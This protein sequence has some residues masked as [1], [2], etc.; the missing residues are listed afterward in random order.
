MRKIDPQ[1]IGY[2]VLKSNIISRNL[3]IYL[4]IFLFSLISDGFISDNRYTPITLSSIG[5]L[6]GIYLLIRHWSLFFNEMRA[7]RYLYVALAFL[8]P[9]GV[10][11]IDT[12]YPDKRT[13]VFLTMFLY[14]FMGAVPIYIL[15]TGGNF[16]RLE[17][18]T[19]FALLFIAL[20]AISQ[21]L[22]GYHTLGHNPVIGSR[23]RGIFGDWSH[24]S[25][26]L[27]T[28]APIMF[29][30][31]YQKIEERFTWLKVIG[32]IIA[33]MLLVTGVMLGG[34]RAGIISLGVSLLLFI[35]YLF[36]T[37]RIKYKWRFVGIVLLIIAIS[38]AILS[39]SEVIQARFI[40][41]ITP[42]EGESF[43]YR[44][45]TLRTNIWYV[46][47]R[48]VPNYWFNGVGTRGFDAL[49]QTYPDDYKIFVKIWHPHLHGLE[50]LIETG[51][52]G[53]IPYLI[54]CFYLL[55]RMFKAKAGNMW[56]MMGFVAL[57]PIN[58][59]V[60]L[61]HDYWFPIVWIPIMIGLAL[62]YRSRFPA[63]VPIIKSLKTKEVV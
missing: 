6:I 53:F 58:S 45:T 54:V 60:G 39:Q 12:L 23:V 5:A 2:I 4:F 36:Y 26:F 9:I 15:A 13:P 22:F 37:D 25:Y 31:L 3:D 47:F 30:Y 7:N 56:L 62:D 44:F 1:N 35:I 42:R 17:A 59:H 10:A 16:K 32:A 51:F 28:F 55:V 33:L 34:A 8:I 49:Y 20:D 38:I 29:F 48:E 61:Y 27:G 52:L 40:S 50:V 63:G 21:W 19:T 41:T 24:L 11:M 18:L 46:G 14:L 57:M 43:L